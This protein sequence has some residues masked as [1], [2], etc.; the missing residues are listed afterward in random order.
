MLGISYGELFL[1]IGATAAL[2]GP[3]DL[4]IIARNA[5]RIAGRAI[6]YVQ[7]ARGQFEN[8]MQQSEA[9]QVHKELQET[10]SQLEAIRYEIRSISLMNPGPM[11]RKL[12]DDSQDSTLN[13]KSCNSLSE[14]RQEELK[15]TNAK[16]KDSYVETSDSINLHSKAIGYAKLAESEAVRSSSLQSS[17]AK[18]NLKDESGLL[19]VLPV[20]AEST[21]LLPKRNE[22][23]QGSDVV[24]E[25]ILEAEVAHNAKDFFSQPQNQI[26]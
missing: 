9:R 22:N 12:M 2:V 13:G 1:L 5:G 24:L 3:K 21:G 8:V 7:L 10:M 26:Q 18:E 6:G 20:S 19:T 25:A 17:A 16:M 23:L 15:S 14:K 11:T 4:P